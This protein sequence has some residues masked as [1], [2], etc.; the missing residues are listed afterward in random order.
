VRG[1]GKGLTHTSALVSALGEALESYAARHVPRESLIRAP[2]DEVATEAF[3]PRWLCLYSPEQYRRPGFPYRPFDSTSPMLW[4]VGRWLDSEAPVLLPAAAVYLSAELERE[5]ALCQTTSNGLAAGVDVRNAA[6]RAALEL[7]ERGELLR[8]WLSY[9]PGVAIETDVLGREYSKVL[10]A[11]ESC[12]AE[13][14]IHLLASEPFV[15]LCTA[16][17]D[18]VRWPGITLGLGAGRRAQEAAQAALLEQGQTGPYLARIWRN[19]ERPMPASKEDIR[20]FEDHALY[21]CDPSHSD[22]FDFLSCTA[23][24]PLLPVTGVRIAIADVTTPD[25]EDSPFRV[26]RA[27]ARGLQPLHYGVGFERALTRRVKACL[28]GKPPNRA[29]VPIC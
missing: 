23:R 3:D 9:E 10:H 22:A 1:H 12:G 27:L 20:T 11:L 17:G 5:H 14:R 8:A 7:Y 4:T 19:R 21:Y 24:G 25:L 6:E 15:A 26:V 13:V 29:P 28:G 2:Y 18:G 16:R